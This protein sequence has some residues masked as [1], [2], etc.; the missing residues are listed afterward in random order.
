MVTPARVR[1]SLLPP[2][3]VLFVVLNLGCALLSGV[4]TRLGGSVWAL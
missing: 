1:S 3:G 2:L 4:L